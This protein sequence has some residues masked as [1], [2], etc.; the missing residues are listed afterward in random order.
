MAIFESMDGSAGMITPEHLTLD[1]RAASA[2]RRVASA[3]KALLSAG[4]KS[5]L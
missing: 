4:A 5:F 3:I 1:S 2:N